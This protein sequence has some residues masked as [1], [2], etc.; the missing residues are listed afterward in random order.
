MKN[1]IQSVWLIPLPMIFY[2]TLS[3][4]QKL[5]YTIMQNC[6]YSKMW[7]FSGTWV[8]YATISTTYSDSNCEEKMTSSSSSPH[9]RWVDEPTNVFSG[10]SWTLN[11]LTGNTV[12]QWWPLSP[13]QGCRCSASLNLPACLFF[14][15]LVLLFPPQPPSH[16]QKMHMRWIYTLQQS[17]RGR[18]LPSNAERH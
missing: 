14:P 9:A 8:W 12:V 16:T 15:P 10:F 17:G 18:S 6:T 1:N 3:P 11:S 4:F 2:C 13:H 5:A 7:R